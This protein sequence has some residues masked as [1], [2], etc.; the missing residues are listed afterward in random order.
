MNRADAFTRGLLPEKR[1]G[2]GSSFSFPNCCEEFPFV[3]VNCYDTFFPGGVPDPELER[4]NLLID[5]DDLT[6]GAA[7]VATALACKTHN[8]SALRQ[9]VFQKRRTWRSDFCALV[10][11]IPG[12]F[13]KVFNI[14]VRLFLLEVGHY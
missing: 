5:A 13:R 10:I 6:H 8:N 1:A 4:T 11:R 3:L 7:A 14:P 2:E 12:S 9:V